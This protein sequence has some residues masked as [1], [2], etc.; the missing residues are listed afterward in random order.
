MWNSFWGLTRTKLPSMS[1]VCGGRSGIRSR[2]SAVYPSG[3]G[4]IRDHWSALEET[5]FSATVGADMSLPP[6]VG[7]CSSPTVA[8][9]VTP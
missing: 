3:G 7:S 9:P 1:S 5:D 2:S 4:W 8:T 6:V